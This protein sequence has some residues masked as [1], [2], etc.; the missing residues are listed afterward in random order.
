MTYQLLANKEYERTRPQITIFLDDAYEI[1]YIPIWYTRAFIPGNYR[2]EAILSCIGLKPENDRELVYTITDLVPE[3]DS[4]RSNKEYDKT[5]LILLT[6]VSLKNEK[7]KENYNL[8]WKCLGRI[9]SVL[10]DSDNDDIAEV[11]VSN[12]F[13]IQIGGTVNG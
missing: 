7:L 5:R 3:R 12:G 4:T 1:V 9:C 8:F 6:K 10:E 11:L 2:R 13:D